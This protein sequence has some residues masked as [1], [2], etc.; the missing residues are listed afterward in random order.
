MAI[1]R[2]QMT[3]RQQ[4]ANMAFWAYWQAKKKAQAEGRAITEDRWSLHAKAHMA[5]K[6]YGRLVEN[7]EYA[8]GSE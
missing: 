2:S 5:H 7:E 8:V 1:H 3:E 4:E 6:P